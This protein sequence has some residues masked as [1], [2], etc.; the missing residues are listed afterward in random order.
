MELIASPCSW[1]SVKVLSITWCP[2]CWRDMFHKDLSTATES[3]APCQPREKWCTSQKQREFIFDLPRPLPPKVRDMT[4][5]NNSPPPSPKGWTCPCGCTWGRNKSNW[6]VYQWHFR[7]SETS[8]SLFSSNCVPPF[9]C[10]FFFASYWNFLALKKFTTTG[11]G[12]AGLLT[13]NTSG[14][15]CYVCVIIEN[16]L[17]KITKIKAP[18]CFKV[19]REGVFFIYRNSQF[20]DSPARKDTLPTPPYR[21]CW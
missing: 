17:A 5:S 10:F 4:A 3:A 6:T 21:Q 20:S 8:S 9:S 19:S 15:Q 14:R 11:A 7:Q 12:Y 13:T 16:L 1:S 18:K 2:V